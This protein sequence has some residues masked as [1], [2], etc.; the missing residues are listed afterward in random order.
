MALTV[1]AFVP[2]RHKAVNGCLVKF[3]V[4]RCEPVSHVLLDIVVWGESFAP[5]SLFL[6]T[7]NGVIAEREVWT[8]WRVTEN[9]PLQFLHVCRNRISRMRPC[10]V[11][12]QCE[13]AW[14][15]SFYRLMKGGQ[16]LQ[17]MLDI[18]YYPVLQEV[19]QKETVLVKEERQHNFICTLRGLL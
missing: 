8:V 15:L 2:L 5:Q 19:L 12:E 11:M 14:S 16:D 10:I 7:K 3:L 4:L 1:K 13:L 9:L 17:V 18:H 6:G